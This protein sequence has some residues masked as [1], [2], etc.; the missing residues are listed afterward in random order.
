MPRQRRHNVRSYRPAVEV[1]EVRNLLST[2]TVDHLADDMVG[3]GPYGSLRYCI[4]QA[5]DGDDITFGD[6]VTGVMNLAGALPDLAHS[7]NLSIFYIT[8]S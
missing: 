4:T 7:V 2:Y 8:S 1:L 3:N 6:G 5:A